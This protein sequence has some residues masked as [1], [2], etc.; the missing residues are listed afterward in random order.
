MDDTY[1]ESL[2]C[3]SRATNSVSYSEFAGIMAGMMIFGFACDIIGRKKSGT[4]T[5]ILMLVGVSGMALFDSDNSTTL[6]VVFASFFGIF[7]LGVGG[8]YPLTASGASQYHA[9]NTQVALL[10][11]EE[12]HRRRVLL[13]AAQTARRGETIAL[14]FAMQGIGAVVGSLLLLILI[15]SAN[16]SKIDCDSVTSNSTGNNAD[17]LAGIWRGFYLIGLL[18]V[19]M[20]LLYRWLILEESTDHLIVQ[21]R[22]NAR[23]ERLGE[24]STSTYTWKILRFY[25]PRLIGTGGNWTLQNFSFYGLRLFSGPIFRSINPEG[26][27]IVQNGW[28]LFNNLCALVGYYCAARVI[29]IP[30][31]GRKR[32]QMVSFGICAFLFMVTG[33]IFDTAEPQTIMFLVFASSF[34]GNFG[35]NVTTY[36][37]AAETYP[38]ELRATCHGISAFMG[39]LGALFATILFDKMEIAGIFWTCGGSSAL[40]FFLTFVFSVDLTRVSLAE[41]DAQLEL[42]LEGRLHVYKGKLNAP[43]HLSNF[44]MWIDPMPVYDPSWA[45]KLMEEQKKRKARPTLPPHPPSHRKTMS[46]DSKIRRLFTPLLLPNDGGNEDFSSA[47][48]HDRSPRG[49]SP[50]RSL[51]RDAQSISS[52]PEEDESVRAGNRSAKEAV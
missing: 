37:M 13:E 32:L 48:C 28:L 44:E 3:S 23:K 14:V 19:A 8:E 29:D 4:F 25:L 43:E 33:A 30:W 39:K 51:R 34:F 26:D 46:S 6:F 20:L 21:Q 40:G 45:S 11:D 18:S 5:S 36:I 15:R 41:H 22:K 50:S 38:T 16:Q 17:A 7:G 9:K 49:V 47:D 35:A 10:D 1:P 24:A 42:F 2:L 52:V 27:L 12:Q 31:I